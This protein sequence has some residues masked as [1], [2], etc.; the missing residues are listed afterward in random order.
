VG[1]VPADAS[2]ISGNLTV[3]NPSSNGYAFI[4]PTTVATP[5]SSTL[6]V[7]ANK[8]GAN[9]FDVALSSGSLAIIWVGTVGSTADIQLDVTGY[10]K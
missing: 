4:S 8:A 3:V 10:W 5:T 7:T 1:Q 2:G 6:N 9:G